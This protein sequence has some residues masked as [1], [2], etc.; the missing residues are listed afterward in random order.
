M[1]DYKNYNED[2]TK[3]ICFTCKDMLDI[4]LFRVKEKKQGRGKGKYINNVCTKC[5]QQAVTE[6]RR[7]DKG[8]AA[9]I[10]RRTKYRCKQLSLPYD[11]DKKWILERLDSISWKCELTGLPMNL[12]V[13]TRVGF[14]W[15]SISVDRINPKG[16]YTKDNVRFVLNQINIFR[17]DASDDQ[18]YMLA[19]AL[20]DYRGQCE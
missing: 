18:M 1:T 5:E 10:A 9:E 14:N 7:T 13:D 16:G 15:D 20:L 19:K 17:Q 4:E 6:Y 2:R 8:L 12:R 3:K 11:L